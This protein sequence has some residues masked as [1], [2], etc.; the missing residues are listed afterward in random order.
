MDSDS[1]GRASEPFDYFKVGLVGAGSVL[2]EAGRFQRAA[3]KGRCVWGVG[4]D[5]RGV[6][7]KGRATQRGKRVGMRGLTIPLA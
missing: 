4:V 7:D 2:S 6:Q 1:D 5:K 3:W